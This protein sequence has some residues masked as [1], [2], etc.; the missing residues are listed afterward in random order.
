MAAQMRPTK[1]AEK[2][3]GESEI[4]QFETLYRLALGFFAVPLLSHTVGNQRADWA[5]VPLLLA[6]LLLLR[7]VPLLLRK[8][9]PFARATQ[10]VWAERRQLGKRYDSYQW[11]KLLWVGVGLAL[12]MLQSGDTTA[13]RLTV[14]S[15]CLL[16]GALGLAWWRLAAAPR[17]YARHG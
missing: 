3:A 1:A 17:H 4:L 6:A 8:L 12:Y 15:I 11:Q 13:T 7:I 5:L 16:T 2:P 10:L 14:S 9:L